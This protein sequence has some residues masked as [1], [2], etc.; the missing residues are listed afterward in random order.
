MSLAQNTGS[1]N[2][3]QSKVID[4]ISNQLCIDPSTYSLFD[5]CSIKNDVSDTKHAE[6]VYSNL[7]YCIFKFND[8]YIIK[9]YNVNFNYDDK[10]KIYALIYNEELNVAHKIIKN[11]IKEMDK[12]QNLIF[13]Y[14]Y[15]SDNRLNVTNTIKNIKHKPLFSENYKDYIKRYNIIKSYSKSGV[16][17]NTNLLLAGL[18]GTGKTRFV[19][20]IAVYMNYS[21]YNLSLSKNHIDKIDGTKNCI[22]MIEE[23]DKEMHH[24]GSFI[25]PLRVD[26]SQLLCFLDGNIRHSSTIL[27]MTCNDL[28]RVK[29]NKIFS[30]KGRINKI[31]NFGKVSFDQCKHII[32][33]Y[34]KNTISDEQ[35][36][37]FFN[38]L[39]KKPITTIAILSSF[40]QENIFNE[41][42]FEDLDIKN[43]HESETTSG[44]LYN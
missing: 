7:N 22:F 5:V 44:F 29:K 4:Y 36:M 34:Y 31:Y 1:S 39:P 38:K 30:R 43:I 26:E 8:R 25:D 2:N 13:I 40:I 33:I 14:K 23:I 35:I 12:V 32:D 9:I 18:P 27:V 16:T 24:D 3:V 28:E 10:T 6:I 17:F 20:D 19:L 21:I 11:I 15:T 42:A 37:Q 41:V